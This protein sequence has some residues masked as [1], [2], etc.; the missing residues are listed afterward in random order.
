MKGLGGFESHFGNDSFEQTTEEHSSGTVFLAETVDLLPVL[1]FAK[2]IFQV[3]FFDDLFI[4]THV[5]KHSTLL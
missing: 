4:F 2:Q 5:S 3:R 1:L